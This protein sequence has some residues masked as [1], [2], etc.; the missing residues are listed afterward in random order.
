MT[1]QDH[2]DKTRRMPRTIFDVVPVFCNMLTRL[3]SL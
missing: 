2:T 3:I 1:P